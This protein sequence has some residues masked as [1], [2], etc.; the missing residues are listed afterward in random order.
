MQR[1]TTDL[2]AA[3]S[4]GLGDVPD[5][6]RDGNLRWCEGDDRGRLRPGLRS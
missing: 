3:V 5:F 4:Q 2:G 1:A 6:G